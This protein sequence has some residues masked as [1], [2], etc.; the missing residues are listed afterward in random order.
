[1][2]VREI[3]RL[4]GHEST[5]DHRS[6]LEYYNQAGPSASTEQ[7]SSAE[8]EQLLLGAFVADGLQSLLESLAAP[9]GYGHDAEDYTEPS[10]PASPPKLV[11]W[12]LS[13]NTELDSSPEAQ[14]VAQIA[15]RLSEYLFADP[16]SDVDEASD[17]EG[18]ERSE[19]GHDADELQE[20]IVTGERGVFLRYITLLTHFTTQLIMVTKGKTLNKPASV[21]AP[22][23][24]PSIRANGSLGPTESCVVVLNLFPIFN[25]FVSRLVHS[26]CLCT[27]LDRYFR[28]DNWSSSFGC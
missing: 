14:A 2:H 19:D 22:M 1:M 6:S 5:E 27:Y 26:M 12:G 10:L 24:L 20:P 7:H 8:S 4:A 16:S 17:E 21:P 13:E 9:A 11:D 25:S 28:I 18:E 15:Q 23:I 3:R